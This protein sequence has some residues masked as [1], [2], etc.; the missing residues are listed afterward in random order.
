MKLDHPADHHL[1]AL[2]ALWVQAF[3]DPEAFIQ[4]FFR[5]AFAPE[6]CMCIFREDNILAAAY[7]LDVSFSGKKAAY[8]YA[9]ATAPSHQGQGLC[10]SLMQAIHHHLTAQGY[11]GAMLVPGDE[12]LRQ[13]YGKMGYRDFGGMDTLTLLQ[14]DAP[15]SFFRISGET[16]LQLRRAYLPAGGVIQE[17]ENIRYLAQ[18]Y[19]FYHGEDFLFAAAK[20]EEGLFAP[21]FLGN[22]DKIPSILAS[23]G[24]PKGIFRIPGQTPFAMYC[25]LN[26]CDTPGYFAFAFD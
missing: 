6:R 20:L 15:C 13:M 5:T 9:V 14:G 1:P 3:G 18:F 19:G 24:S 7:W 8:I 21:E 26:S 17:E 4:C 10:R 16:F 12:G 25:P 23:L 22:T 11:A 2:Q